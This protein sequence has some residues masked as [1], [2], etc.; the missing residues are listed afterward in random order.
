MRNNI[1]LYRFLN[2]ACGIERDIAPLAAFTRLDS[3]HGTFV[4]QCGESIFIE[5]LALKPELHKLARNELPVLKPGFNEFY[6]AVVFKRHG[7]NPFIVA[8]GTVKTRL[9]VNH[10]VIERLS[11]AEHFTVKFVEF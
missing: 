6:A 9:A 3:E 10:A 8:F 1:V 7:E 5:S 4:P 2:L 11:A